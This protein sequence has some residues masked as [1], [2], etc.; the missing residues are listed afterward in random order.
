MTK[1]ATSY[2]LE[3]FPVMKSQSLHHVVKKHG[4]SCLIEYIAISSDVSCEKA[5]LA[6]ADALSFVSAQLCTPGVDL[7]SAERD[8]LST[9]AVPYRTP[10]ISG[11]RPF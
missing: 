6:D 4:A 10:I 5:C 3:T 8:C 1:R 9:K 7:A 11:G 2:R